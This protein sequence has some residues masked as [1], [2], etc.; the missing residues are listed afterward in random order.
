MQFIKRHKISSGVFLLI[1]IIFIALQVMIRVIPLPLEGILRPNSVL[2]FDR[3]QELL[4]A[5]TSSDEM[6]RIW[7]PL[8]KISPELQKFLLA[9]EDKWFYSHPGINPLAII[10][11]AGQNLKNG[12]II[13]GGSTITMQIARMMEPKERTLRNKIIEAFRTL[14]L[15]YYFTKDELLEIYFNIAPYGGNIEGAAAA[16]WLYF[17]KEPFQLSYAEAALLAVLPNSPVLN[18]PDLYPENA[19]K[20]RDKVLMRMVKFDKLLE[21]KATEAM[22]ESVPTQRK[23]W[24][25]IAPHFTTHLKLNGDQASRVISTIDIKIQLTAEKLLRKHLLSLKEL[26]ITNGAI[27]IIDNHTHELRAMVGSNDFFNEKDSGQVNGALAPRSPGSTLKPFTFGLALMQ[28][29]ISPTHYLEDVPVDYSGYSPENYDKKFNGIVSAEKA[30]LHSLNVPAVNLDYHLKLNKEFSLYDLLKIANLSTIENSDIYGLSLVLGSCEVN[31]LELTSLYSVFASKGKLFPIKKVIDEELT[32]PIEIF[33]SGT[34]YIISEILANLR[35]PDLPAVWEFTSL[36]KVAWKTGTS[37]GHRDA[38]SIG[39]NPN[40]T[41]GIW[42]GNFN[43]TASPALIGANAAAPLLFDLFAQLEKG[44]DTGWFAQPESVQ[45]RQV[46]SLS[47]QIPNDN[48]PT[49]V[50]EY[51]LPDKSPNYECNLHKTVLVDKSSGYRLPANYPKDNSVKEVEY[52]N[53]SA[54]VATWMVESGYSIYHLPDLKPEFKQQIVGKPPIIVSPSAN[55]I[56]YLRDE[57]PLKFQKIAFQA[58]VSND[59]KKIFWFLNGKLIGTSK[60]GEKFYYL[61]EVGRHRLICQ[62]DLGRITELEL[63]VKK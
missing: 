12:R 61:P 40:Y 27:V 60:V 2:V 26:G 24:P 28:G 62:D 35:R 19:K 44:F 54:P 31:L 23:E 3:N 25:F 21:S 46:C 41:I 58:S 22:K 39:F 5:F 55:M 34:S 42:I 51:Y 29:I 20:A 57:I 38:W 43:G 49:L 45:S 50:T 30:L 1:L 14:Q 16:S 53:W 17:G 33:D 36:P 18:R 4:R 52:I 32:E 15:E 10:R 37:F 7:T 13:S 56:Y 63:I 59:A 48:C 47:G 8:N 6:W 11:A 9:Y